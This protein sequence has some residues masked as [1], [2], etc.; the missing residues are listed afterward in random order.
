MIAYLICHHGEPVAFVM[1]SKLRAEQKLDK[2]REEHIQGAN[3]LFLGVLLAAQAREGWHIIEM[4][5]E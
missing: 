1:G 3:G 2:L 4:K 5:A